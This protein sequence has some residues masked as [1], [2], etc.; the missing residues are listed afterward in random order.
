LRRGLVAGIVTILAAGLALPAAGVRRHPPGEP[1]AAPIDI[2]STRQSLEY[3]LETRVISPWYPAGMDRE[4][5]G[6][7]TRDS[8]GV[9]RPGAPKTAV[10][11]ARAVWFF[12]QLYYSGYGRT[13]HL[14]AARAGFEFLRDSIWDPVFGGFFWEVDATGRVAVK[15][16]KHTLAQ[17]V[18]LTA[19]CRYVQVTDD[20]T[21]TQ[22]AGDVFAHL[23]K[24]AHDAEFGGYVE[25]L[26]RDWGPAFAEVDGYL[27]V[28][29]RLKL[30][31]THLELI[32]ALASYYR[33]TG[34]PVAWQRLSELI[35]SPA[36]P[37]VPGPKAPRSIAYE[38]DWTPV[39]APPFDRAHCEVD[40]ASIRVLGRSCEDVDLSGASH[41]EAYGSLF[42]RVL[43][44]AYDEKSGCFL[45][46]GATRRSPEGTCPNAR[47]QA[48]ALVAGL[49]LYSQTGEP[50][51]A[52]VSAGTL[53]SLVRALARPASGD[54]GVRGPRQTF[55]GV[56][57]DAGG[58]SFH[59]GRALLNALEILDRLESAAPGG[60]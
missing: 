37:M 10:D 30:A 53:I 3:L 46:P 6:F 11:Q 38:R 22:L 16:H 60:R 28:D 57:P 14:A 33:M 54:T 56:Y 51:Y 2:A 35:S 42:A 4:H 20:S 39:L 1:E 21:A 44:Q 24:H 59:L 55:D 41:Q 29:S 13:E 7:I 25:Q 9:W 23:D 50:G 26:R 36:N 18:A 17:A 8:G 52:A 12:S 43:Q 5:G 19:L 15:P 49:F 58:G 34:D 45:E 27:G 48:E 31:S 47:L 40:L 32:D